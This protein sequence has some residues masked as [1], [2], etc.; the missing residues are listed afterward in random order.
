MSDTV[1]T[2][3]AFEL[4]EQIVG[5]IS[6]I[7]EGLKKSGLKMKWVK[8]ENI[9]LTLKFLGNIKTS[10]VEKVDRAMT[11]SSRGVDPISLAV[12]GMG[13]F[14][15]LRRPRVLWVGITGGVNSILT[16]HSA[17][18]ENLE[19]IGFP[20]ENRPFKGHLTVGRVKARIDSKI[21]ADAMKAFETF[22]SESFIAD[23]LILFQSELRPTGA[24]YTKLKTQSLG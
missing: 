5:A 6:Q 9:H 18:E 17:I 1:R 22:E 10:D 15:D 4:P 20:K 24:V 2:F 8:P 7:Q 11:R 13:V 21:L 3:I 16:L 23:H 12:K 19:S 14:P